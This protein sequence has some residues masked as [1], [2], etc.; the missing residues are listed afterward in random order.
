MAI[1]CLSNLGLQALYSCSI[2]EPRPL[3]PL[4]W[5]ANGHSLLEQ[6]RPS[7]PLLLVQ[8]PAEATPPSPLTLANIARGRCPPHSKS[9]FSELPCYSLISISTPPDKSSFIR[10]STVW[11]VGSWISSILL[12]VRISNCS[13]DFLST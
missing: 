12:C 6:F 5:E 11:G 2:C 3:C 13:L 4:A 1:A 8:L 9:E 7:S 10:A